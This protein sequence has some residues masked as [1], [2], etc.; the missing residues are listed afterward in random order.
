ML[1]RMA[2]AFRE[3]LEMFDKLIVSEPARTEVQH[4]RSYFLVSS[5]IVG[6]LFITA[7]VVSIYAEDFGLGSGCLELVEIVSPPNL[8]EAVAPKPIA[9]Q[10]TSSS[11]SNSERTMRRENIQNLAETPRA[12]TSI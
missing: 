12:D 10:R 2:P 9:R 6:I 1:E 5:V 7:V 8:A 4:R 3:D 11:P